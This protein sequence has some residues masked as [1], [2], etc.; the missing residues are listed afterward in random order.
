M[1]LAT[2]RLAR[3]EPSAVSAFTYAFMCATSE[4]EARCNPREGVSR[5]GYETWRVREDRC[6]VL[7]DSAAFRTDR[8]WRYA[9]GPERYR[10]CGARRGSHRCRNDLCS[11]ASQD[12]IHRSPTQHARND[13]THA[14]GTGAATM[15]RSDRH[16]VYVG[17]RGH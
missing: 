1:S 8:R 15:A 14:A 9:P 4:A 13:E 2:R 12:G 17:A 6:Q 11:D 16:T 10:W 3:E 7:A 5:E